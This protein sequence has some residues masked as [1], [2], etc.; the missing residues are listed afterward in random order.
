LQAAP[1]VTSNPAQAIDGPGWQAA[2]KVRR[3]GA[4]R[5]HGWRIAI[6]LVPP[7]SNEGS[8]FSGHVVFVWSSE[9]HT[10][11]AGYHDVVSIASTVR[12]D[13]ALVGGIRL[14]P[15]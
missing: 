14:L 3:I 1:R 8:A 7:L 15:R 11:A 13:R 5:I 6:Y 12:W 10:Y 2:D 9:G 4:T